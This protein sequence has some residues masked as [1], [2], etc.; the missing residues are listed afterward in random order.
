MKV[1][2]PRKEGKRVLVEFGPTRTARSPNSVTDINEIMRRAEK[3][4]YLLDSN[5]LGN[6]P[7]IYGD[8]TGSDFETA[9][10]TIAKVHS[11]FEAL[12]AT[13]REDFGNDPRNLLDAMQSE[14][15]EII[16]YLDDN[17]IVHINALPEAE[18]VIAAEPAKIE[19]KGEIIAPSPDAG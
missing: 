9:M 17:G 10:N 6:R 7:Q 18:S 13:V 2:C 1:E 16:K 5:A 3:A 14:D 19:P 4:G 15:P 8:F 12:P 11:D